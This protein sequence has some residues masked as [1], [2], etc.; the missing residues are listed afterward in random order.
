MYDE[1]VTNPPEPVQK[2]EKAKSEKDFAAENKQKEP[3]D[4]EDREFY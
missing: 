1:T 4:L 3:K 2:V